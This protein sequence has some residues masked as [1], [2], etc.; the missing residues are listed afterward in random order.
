[1][2]GILP[3]WRSDPAKDN[4]EK[5]LDCQDAI[6]ELKNTQ[7]ELLQEKIEAYVTK[8]DQILSGLESASTRIQNNMDMKEAWGSSASAKDYTK[9]NKNTLSQIHNT[10]LQRK[11]LLELRATVKKGTEAWREYNQ[12]VSESDT[13][14]QELTKSMAENAIAQASLAKAKADRKNERK[15]TADGMLDT[16]LSTA[17]S[18]STKNRLINAKAKNIDS[19]QGSLKAAYASSESSR[20][21]FGGKIQ[22]ASQKGV[23]KKNKRLFQK[24]IKC[25]KSKKLVGTSIISAVANAMKSAKGREYTALNNLLSYCSSYNAYKEAEEENRLAYEMYVLTAQAEK[26][27]LREEQL[28]NKLDNRQAIADRATTSIA[29]TASAKN[30]NADIQA[31]LAEGNAKIYTSIR[32]STTADR[33]KAAKKADFSSEK[34]YKKATG[35]LKQ[36]LKK[37]ASAIKAGKKITSDG[38]KAVKEYCGKYLNGNLTYYYSCIAYNEAVENE[39][40]AKDAETIANVEAYATRLQTRIDNAGNT[41]SGRDE[42]NELYEATAK[43][44][45]TAG[46]KNKYVDLRSANIGRNLSTYKSL[47]ESMESSFSSMRNKVNGTKGK[48]KGSNSIIS[49]VKKYTA[50][51][52][53][54]PQSLITK[55]YTVSDSFGR[56]CEKYNESLEARNA[57]KETYELYKQTAQ[58]EQASLAAE[59]MENI[60]REYENRMSVHTQKAAQLNNAIDLAQAK[61]YQ[62]SKAFY[63][64]LYATEEDRN[65]LLAQKRAELVKSLSESVQ[66]GSIVKYTDE[67]YE[68]A[69]QIDDVTNALDESA[70]SLEEYK[71]QMRQIEWDNFEYLEGRISDTIAEMDFMVNELSRQPLTSDRTGSLT[72]A[73][74]AVAMLHAMNYNVYGQQAEDYAAQVKKIDEELAEDPYNKTLID[75]KR[76][77]IKAAQDSIKAAEDEKYAIIDLYKQGYEALIAKVRD[78]ISEYSDLLDAEK[79]AFDYSNNIT[80]KAKEIANIRKQLEAY[81]GDISE[82]TRAKVQTLSVSLDDAERDLQETQYDKYI[83]DTKDMLSGL[84]DDFEDAIQ[85]LIDNLHIE[86]D[87]LV[88]DINSNAS[89]S[90]E[91]IAGKMS[92]IG[93]LGTEEFKAI[94]SEISGSGGTG[95]SVGGAADKIVDGVKESQKEM[96]DAA[97]RDAGSANMGTAADEIPD[98]KDEKPESGKPAGTFVPIPSGAGSMMTAE[99]ALKA[100]HKDEGGTGSKPKLTDPK[101][102]GDTFVM[103]KDRQANITQAELDANTRKAEQKAY[104]LDYIKRHVSATKKEYGTFTD[105]N[106]KIYSNFGSKVLST[107]E[108]KELAAGLGIK[109]DNAKSTGAL[110]KKLK[111]LGVKGFRDGSHNIPYGQLAFLGEGV[112]ELQFDRSQGVLK[113]VGQGDKVFT[114]KM[115]ENLWK[116]ASADPSIL[117]GGHSLKQDIVPVR[118]GNGV[119]DV[120]ISFGD[121]TLPDVTDSAEFAKSVKQV[122]RNAICDDYRTQKC[123]S[124]AISS[125]MLGKGIGM[126]RHWKN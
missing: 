103:V 58:T 84:G 104:A 56:A 109:Y 27:S 81:A 120:N 63:G 47:H 30:R 9:L 46:A 29:E 108:M 12:R 54:I 38:L 22:K 44:Q 17:S 1:M 76:E 41:V 91:T 48:D 94:L 122:M 31:S 6:R 45:K 50:K 101:Q 82:E 19:R 36:R 7:R 16:R 75:Q 21:K 60:D 72:D 51:N 13:S 78:L 115:A 42:Q 119:G 55:A 125:Q 4:D 24:A 39:V 124:E 67:W 69:G 98:R 88:K 110:Y 96:Q 66:D 105:L 11:K 95:D 123:F 37:A 28:Q 92:G 15:D 10:I 85:E 53:F 90:A 97:D 32:K 107:K 100:L 121:L 52:S 93:Y 23:S 2:R 74:D 116:V 71:N 59:K 86:F 26:K 14:I 114:G 64:K 35:K 8:Y 112:N 25:V 73:G 5:A 80:D 79:D 113:E 18:A 43:N 70:L 33:K 57:A 65:A 111:S 87:R 83:S 89:T 126:A 77:Y 118:A 49:E 34:T 68:L 20:V 99:E 62:A 106:K 102:A 40:S 61:G 3:G 117:L